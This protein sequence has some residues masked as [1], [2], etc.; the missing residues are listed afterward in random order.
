MVKLAVVFLF[1][2]VACATIHT[3]PPIEV[4]EDLPI[5]ELAEYMENFVRE[6][7]GNVRLKDLADS[8]Y[9]FTRLAWSKGEGDE[10]RT[11]AD[12][13]QSLHSAPF[14]IHIDKG[15][16]AEIGKEDRWAI[17]FHEWGHCA[18]N[19]DHT[20]ERGQEWLLKI[21]ERPGVAVQHAH[22]FAD[23]CPDSLMNWQVPHRNCVRAHR[24][25]YMDEL[26][27][28]CKRPIRLVTGPVW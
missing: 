3:T 27:K 10:I 9:V 11:I 21:L 25:E 1:L 12:C 5:K 4:E 23:G 6:S 16:W 24:D 19:R 7:H 22:R 2:G 13:D 26:F 28:N 20:V 14:T 8:K 15:Y 17:M 18:C